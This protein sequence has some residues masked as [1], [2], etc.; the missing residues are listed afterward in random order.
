MVVGPFQ[1]IHISCFELFFAT[2][3]GPRPR[4][5]HL[6]RL[7]GGRVAW[8]SSFLRGIITSGWNKVID[9]VKDSS[10]IQEITLYGEI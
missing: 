7:D 10:P 9:S 4:L 8:S 6:L 2:E 5:D 1:G 3:N